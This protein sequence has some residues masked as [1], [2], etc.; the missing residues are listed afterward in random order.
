[1]KFSIIIP[2]HNEEQVI[3]KALESI[4][5]Q[6]FTDY[7]MIVVCDAC[8]DH[9]KEIAES[10]GAKVI[11]I[12]GHSSARARNA[13]LDAAIGDWVLFCDADDWYL[14]EFVFQQ[15][16]QKLEE[17]QN[18]DL[19]LFTLIWKGMG[20]CKVRSPKGT[21]YPHVANKCWRRS[22]IGSTRFPDKE[23]SVGEDGN[24]LQSMLNKSGLRM[25]EWDMPLYYYNYLRP[26][27]KSDQLGR[28][29][30]HSQKY[31]SNH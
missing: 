16:A 5:Q 1:M 22:T 2:A 10:Y 25:L 23:H 6:S 11:E 15:L 14:H 20:Y 19:L 4:K 31:W 24:F 28:S 3:S 18:I 9:T 13:G 29:I 12:Q 30:A 7:E 27:S 21:I 26:G 8:T 17:N